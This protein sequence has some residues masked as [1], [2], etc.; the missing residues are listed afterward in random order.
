FNASGVECQAVEDLR[1]ARW[2]KLIWNIPFN[3]L[4]AVMDMTTDLLL[5][6]E[7]G[8]ALVKEIMGEVVDIARAIGIEFP[9]DIAEQQIEF[10]KPMGA[11]RTSMQIDR[12]QGRP[13]EIGAMLGEPLAVARQA[14]VA[15]PRL[16]ML[17]TM[18]GWVSQATD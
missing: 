11:Y 9:A 12:Q 15:A 2:Q 6:S 18:A 7:T 1:R 8:V 13:L 3:A 17:H 14:G 16:E 4:G 5:A 10:T